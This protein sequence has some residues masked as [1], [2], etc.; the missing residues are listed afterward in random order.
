MENT[1]KKSGPTTSRLGLGCT[2]FGREISEAD[3]FALMDYAVANGITLFDTAEAYGGGQARAY[4]R[5]RLGID[6]TREVSGE[7]HSSEKIIG[8]WLRSRGG[9]DRITLVTK[10][11]RNFRR[12]QV[13]ASLEASLQRL[14]SDRVEQYLYHSFDPAT[15]VD[16]ANQ[17]MDAVIKIGLTRSGGCSNYTGTQLQAALDDSRRAGLHPFKVVQLGYSLVKAQD[18][19]F[20]I[21]AREKLSFQAYSPLAAGFLS[22]KYT[23]DRSAIPKGTRFDVIPAHADIYFND[24]NFQRVA[25]LHQLA[26]RVGVPPLQLAMAWVL[27]NPLVTTVLVGARSEAHLANA[28]AAE[29]LVFAPEWLAEIKDWDAPPGEIP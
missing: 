3:A 6:D 10:T 14:Q 28:L 7:M 20:E 25:R 18:Q 26:A 29:R 13:R 21:V 8:R 11:S 16:E 5:E 27:L 19:V 9:R 24:R 17:A 2:T 22:G 15:P 4:R 23:A 1:S 12:E